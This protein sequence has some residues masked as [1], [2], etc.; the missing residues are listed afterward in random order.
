MEEFE[1][2]TTID[3]PI[4][5]VWDFL[6]DFKRMP[7]WNAGLVE[8]RP[9]SEGPIGVGSTI[10]FRGKFLGRSVELT[11][12]YTEYAPKR[13]FV[14]R[15]KAGPLHIELESTVESIPGGTKLT[16]LYRGESHGFFKLTEPVIVRV[17]KKQ[18]ESAAE[19]MKAL[20]E[21]SV[22]DPV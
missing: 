13:R 7:E 21:A 2:V 20:L 15:T 1:I 9:T 8:A 10:V 14:A 16:S 6:E 4:D 3:R 22:P 12:E 11:Q 19:N 17:A 18:F 5:E